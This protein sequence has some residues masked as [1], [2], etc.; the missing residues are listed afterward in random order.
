MDAFKTKRH[1]VMESK[2]DQHVGTRADFEEWI[3]SPPYEREVTRFSEGSAWP[4]SY[5]ELDVDL[6]WQ[7]WSAA[8]SLTRERRAALCDK[9]QGATSAHGD[10]FARRIRKSNT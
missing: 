2:F 6:A 5:R 8:M 1:G 7:A 3:S 10:A 4:G 9:A